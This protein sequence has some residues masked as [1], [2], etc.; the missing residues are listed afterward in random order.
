MIRIFRLPVLALALLPALAATTPPPADKLTTEQ[1][2]TRLTSAIENLKTLRCNV[3]AQ[4]R[5]GN[6]YQHARTAMKMGFNPLRVYLRNDKGIEVLWVT[7]QND[8]DA[9]VYPNSFPYVTLSLDPNG[10]IMRRNQH[11]SVLDAGF[12]TIA[13]IIKGSKQRQDHVFERT[14]RYASDTTIT[15]RPCHILRSDFPQFRYVPYK[16]T[17]PE[18]LASIADRFGCG[19]YRIMERNDLSPDATVP[20]GKTLQVPNGYG[21]RTIIC[22]DQK[23]FLPLVVQVQDDK[24]LFEKFEF[25]DVV[26]NQPIPAAEFAKGY[27]GYKL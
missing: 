19:E 16:T 20:A 4:E 21:K 24:G 6:K 26:A 27:K 17:K 7:G 14:F 10:S 23:L 11:H 9:W 13:D 5:S 8:G 22:V 15:G 18:T 3:R 25:S 2:L 1:L 12:G